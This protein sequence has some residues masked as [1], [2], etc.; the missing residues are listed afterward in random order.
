MSVIVVVKDGVAYYRV[1]KDFSKKVYLILVSVRYSV[2]PMN[3]YPTGMG[4]G[5]Y[6]LV[7][8]TSAP[9]VTN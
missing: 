8:L 7:D 1:F 9:P 6:L 4:R 3:T 2:E 5:M